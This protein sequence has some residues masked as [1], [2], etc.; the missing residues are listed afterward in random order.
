M[1]EYYIHYNNMGKTSTFK[2]RPLLECQ[3]Y[4][5]GYFRITLSFIIDEKF[6]YKR[7]SLDET[8]SNHRREEVSMITKI[9]KKGTPKPHLPSQYGSSLYLDYPGQ[10]TTSSIH[11]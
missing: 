10:D 2:F 6:F 9:G 3:T 5:L 8:L 4:E 7:V 1:L 11:E